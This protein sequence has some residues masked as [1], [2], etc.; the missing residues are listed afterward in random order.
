MTFAAQPYIPPEEPEPETTAT[1]NPDDSVTETAVAPDGSK[2]ETTTTADGSTGTVKTGA[3]GSAVS[4][5]AAPSQAA[6]DEAA[7]SG[8]PV[9]LPV[10]VAAADSAEDA[11]PIAITL[12]ETAERVTVE[13]PVENLTPGTVAVLVHADGTEEIIKTSVTSENGVVLTL[14]GSATVK[15]VD[16][17]KVLADVDAD[18]WYAD[19]A[20]W[21]ASRE[22]MVGTGAGFAPETD[23]SRGMF[24]QLLF[25]LDGAQPS[26]EIAP[27]DDVAAG[28]WY[29]DSVTWLVENG[30]AQGKGDTF[31]PNGPVTR[32][33]VA[34]LM[35]RFCAL[36]AQ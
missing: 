3:D 4:A 16:N 24:A 32:A 1:E 28:D 10:E 11:V 36:V 20:A 15:I 34:A 6:V 12:P 23:T 29:A 19:A 30:I 22:I 18:A 9:T 14:D 31:D 8:E 27:F 17:T 25:N 21:A 7:V 13:I 35:Q 2:A 5:E 26:G 33:Q